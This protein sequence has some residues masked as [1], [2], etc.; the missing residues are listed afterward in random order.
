MEDISNED[1]SKIVAESYSYSDISRKIGVSIGTTNTTKFKARI[2][3]LN[4][5]VSHFDRGMANRK[6]PLVEKN[7]PVCDVVFIASSGSPDEKTTCSYSCSN[8]FFRSGKNHPNWKD[9]GTDYRKTALASY[10]HR[11]NRC[12]YDKYVEVL[13]VHHINRNRTDNS[14]ENL[15]VL[16][17]NCHEEEHFLAGDGRWTSKNC[18]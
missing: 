15:E 10:P 18:D 5:D 17:W 14:L 2:K 3:E 12:G 9:S 1:F 8:T 7:C 16:C 11:C 4:L 6:Y 13:T